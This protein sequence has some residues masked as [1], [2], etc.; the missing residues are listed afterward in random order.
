MAVALSACESTEQESEKIGREAAHTSTAAASLKLG[1]PNSRVRVSDLT[2]LSSDGRT[3]VAARLT[4]A[5]SRPQVEV[6]VEVTVTGRGGVTLYTN[7]HGEQESSL[8]HVAL[9]GAHQSVWWVDDQVLTSQAASGVKLTVG[10]GRTPRAGVL[11]VLAAGDVTRGEQDGV[12]T[13]SGSL[14]NHSHTAQAKVAVFVVLL[15]GGH[16]RAAGRAVV[17]QLAGRPGASAPFQAFL[18]GAGTGTVELSP[19]PSAG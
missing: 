18:V 15:G 11:P 19:V 3:A 14:V 5:S 10:T 8:Q 6:P 13:V 7:S 12:T 2:L 17:D 9:L 4:S 16:V 1:A